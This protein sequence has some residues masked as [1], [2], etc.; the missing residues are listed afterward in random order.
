MTEHRLTG[1]HIRRIA[2]ATGPCDRHR[3]IHTFADGT[4]SAYWWCRE[5]RR[6]CDGIPQPR[7][8]AQR[9]MLA[10]VPRKRCTDPEHVWEKRSR[11][12]GFCLTCKR[13]Y[14]RDRARE[15]RAA[16]KAA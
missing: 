6:A 12:G 9:V 8:S 4:R 13:A 2:H 10:V 16:E 3:R 7:Q 15:R 11:N 5:H 14:N 1:V